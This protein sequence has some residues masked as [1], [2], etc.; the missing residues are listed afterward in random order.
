MTESYAGRVNID[1]S[2]PSGAGAINTPRSEYRWMEEYWKTIDLVSDGFE[3]AKKSAG[4]IIPQLYAEEPES[5]QSRLRHLDFLPLFSRLIDLTASMICRKAITVTKEE[6]APVATIE[7]LKEHLEDIDSQGRSLDSFIRDFLKTQIIYSIAGILIDA[8][9]KPIGK[10]ISLAEEKKYNLRPYW[11]AIKPRDLI[12]WRHER[13]GAANILVHLRIRSTIEKTVGE[14]GVEIVPIIKVYDLTKGSVVSRVFIQTEEDWVEDEDLR[15]QIGL[16]YIPYFAM[17][18]NPQGLFT[19]RPEMYELAILNIGHTRTS[20]DLA[21]AL[22]LAAHPKLKR[23]R[24]VQFAED[25][26]NE[27]TVD[28]APNKV[29]TPGIGEDYEWLSAPDSAFSALERK[30]EKYEE[31][32]RKMFTM[33]ILGQ[34]NGVESAQS[35]RL[36]QNQGNSSLLKIVI[37][38]DSLLEN[39]IQAHC[40]LMDVT[41]I[42]A[43]P[44]ICL[45]VN[46]DLAAEEMSVELLQ[47]YSE[48]EI[49]GQISKRTLLEAIMRGQLLWEDFDIEAE[50]IQVDRDTAGTDL[51]DANV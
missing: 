29:L 23:L 51:V 18:T 20:S 47:E 38:L 46:R 21:F 3:S 16:P 26:T 17:N 8:P 48:L 41:A 45:N 32:S 25:Y 6:D 37:E 43:E 34:T 44:A 9:S 40:D 19:A 2:K 24:T 33:M 49:K 13:V 11:V 15:S 50:L 22:N 4:N 12:S 35:K 42:G 7:T 14:F 39:C 28:M 30:V 10:K 5:Y 1:I 31:D 27:S 36:N